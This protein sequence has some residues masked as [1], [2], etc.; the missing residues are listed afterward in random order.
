MLG[1]APDKIV[2]D[3]LGRHVI[4][5]AARRAALGIPSFQDQVYD[6]HWPGERLELLG[7]ASDRSLAKR[8]GLSVSAV[9]NARMVRGIDPFVITPWTKAM[10]GLL[11]TAC[12]RKIA[13]RL[14]MSEHK[15]R[16]RREHLGVKAWR[17]RRQ[18]VWTESDDALLEKFDDKVVATMLDLSAE[19]VKNR[20]KILGLINSPRLTSL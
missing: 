18:H 10:D 6:L 7:T 3:Q 19:V 4:H 1:S 11:G 16:Y 15:V 20:L 12:D 17:G 2:A 9:S 13:K 8:W 5:V 14:R